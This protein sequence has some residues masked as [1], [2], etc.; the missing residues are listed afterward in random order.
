V[1]ESFLTAPAAFKRLCE[2]GLKLSKSQFYNLMNEGHIP[3]V[4]LKGHKR[5]FIRKSDLDRL[6]QPT[7][8]A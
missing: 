6:L 5:Y 7:P 8:V 3:T 2:I 1:N 4:M